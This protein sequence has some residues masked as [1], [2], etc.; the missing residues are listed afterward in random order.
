MSQVTKRIVC[1]TFI[2]C[3][4]ACG[5]DRPGGQSDVVSEEVALWET[6]PAPHLTLRSTDGGDTLN[7]AY[8]VDGVSTRDGGVA[9][10]DLRGPSIVFFDSTGMRV[11]VVGRRGKGPG[12]FLAPVWIGHCLG[13]TLFVWDRMLMRLSAW[14]PKGEY[15]RDVPAPVGTIFLSCHRGGTIA[16]M[17]SPRA[18]SRGE[19]LQGSDRL[20]TDI[21][22]FSARG[23][24]LGTIRSVSAGQT[25]P[26]G[27]LTR[28]ASGAGR[29][30][31]GTGDSAFVQIFDESGQS[32]GG[33]MLGVARKSATPR[34]FEAA[35]DELV[36]MMA[37]EAQRRN[38]KAM[39]MK[40]DPPALLPAYSELI[41]DESDRLWTVLTAVGDTIS[42]LR[43]AGRSGSVTGDVIIPADFRVFDVEKN[44][45]LGVTSNHITGEQEVRRYR[46]T[47]PGVSKD[48]PP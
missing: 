24:S 42:R 1:V 2:M 30:W 23:D 4:L 47:P 15:L 29:I 36:S 6:E 35:I 37:V 16:A 14:S 33:M 17:Q 43:V 11:R 27:V 5:T 25:R 28:L 32:D 19:A 31:V 13:D 45:V 8:A 46:V 44:R 22:V 34:H 38:A 10:V 12:E 40:G 26:L 21:R 20:M 41:A 39:L 18:L 9:L 3:S 48:V 7:F